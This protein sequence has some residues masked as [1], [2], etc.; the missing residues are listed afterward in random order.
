MFVAMWMTKD[1]VTVEP[2]TTIDAAA[3]LM[4]ERRIR[5]L[6]VLATG[7]YDAPLVGIVSSTDVLHA[8]PL[9]VNPF[10][11]VSPGKKAEIASGDGGKLLVH[12]VMTRTPVTIAADAPIEAAAALMRSR[13]IGAL[14][15]VRGEQLIGLITESDVFRAFSQ[16]F[17]LSAVGA[18]ITFDISQQEDVLPFI[19]NAAERHK[20]RITSFVSLHTLE[21]PMCVVHV[22]GPNIDALLEDVWS[23]HHRVASVIRSEH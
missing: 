22:A 19:A 8:L 11:P 6:P 5:R 4:A 12:D 21:R 7:N 3:R 15:V 17:D 23:S 20:L 18:R 2:H 16:L 13:K 9:S 14:P 10:S 1:I